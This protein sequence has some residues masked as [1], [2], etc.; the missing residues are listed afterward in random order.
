MHFVELRGGRVHGFLRGSGVG[1]DEAFYAPAVKG[2]VQTFELGG[3]TR[4]FRSA[5]KY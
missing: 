3:E 5:V 1:A 2:I 4:L